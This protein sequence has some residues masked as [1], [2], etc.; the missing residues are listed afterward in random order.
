MPSSW[1]AEIFVGF[2]TNPGNIGAVGFETL[3]LFGGLLIFLATSLWVGTKVANRAYSLDPS[4]FTSSTAKPDGFFY[5]AIRFVGGGRSF[6]SLLSSIFKDYSRR[7]E[8]L[9]WIIYA[10]GLVTLI[11]I[12]ISDTS[13][14]PIDQLV[15]LSQ[16][17][18]PF[19]AAFVV[20]TVSRGKDTLFIFKKSPFGIKKFVK[21]RLVQGW[22]VAVPIAAALIAVSTILLPQIRVESL[23]INIVW[24]SLRTFTLVAVVLGLSIINPIFAEESRERNMGII[25]NLMVV[26]FATII[27]EIGLRR[28]GLSFGKMLPDIDSFTVILYDHLFLTMVFSLVGIFLL[29]NGIRKLNRI[30]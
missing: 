10:V 5:K 23:L 15:F 7:L 1:G 4:K 9:S 8:N 18:I 20:G 13:S 26:L 12:F 3:T 27:L 28:I 30:E 25:I 22:L 2:A 19:L 16:M 17:A 14:E 24:G 29:Y 11:R 6:G 21:A